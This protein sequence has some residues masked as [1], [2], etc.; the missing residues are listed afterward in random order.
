MYAD[1]FIKRTR[2]S[3]KVGTVERLFIVL[4]QQLRYQDT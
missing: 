2:P 4:Q 3:E 1:D